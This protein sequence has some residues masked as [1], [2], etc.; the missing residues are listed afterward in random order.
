MAFVKATIS[1]KPASVGTGIK[2]I[3]RKGK[4]SP[5]TTSFSINATI[6]KQASI[7]DGDGIEV[8]I[9]DGEHHGLI[10]IRKNNSAADTKA[11]GRT[12][13]KGAFFLIKL[14]HQPAFVDR[15]EPSAWCQ[16]E[17]VE[18]GWIEI[19]L[20]KW[21]DETAPNRKRADGDRSVTVNG[22]TKALHAN[23]GTTTLS[24]RK[25]SVTA[26]LMGDPPVGRRE[27]LRKMG[28]MKA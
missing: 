25:Q 28:E 23:A 21:A 3:L 14:G 2:C 4:A 10:R 12:T 9:G 11:D 20:P 24:A 13:G 22:V 19:V 27:M 6:A 1:F 18:D 5:A 15:S 7:A 26:G 17:L 8:M 16:W